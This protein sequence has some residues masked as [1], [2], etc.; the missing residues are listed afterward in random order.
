MEHYGLATVIHP[1]VKIGRR[2]RIFHHVTLASESVIGSGNDIEIGDDVLIGAGA[3]V[4]GRGNRRLV[5]GDGAVVGAGAVVTGDVP[6]GE[7]VV[8][9]PA[10]PL[11]SVSQM[12]PHRDGSD[13]Q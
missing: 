13:F 2:V 4:V 10:K 8:G 11:K 12:Q 6:S 5:I 3:I 7:I 9:S 1:N